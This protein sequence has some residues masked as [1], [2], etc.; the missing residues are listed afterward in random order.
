MERVEFEST[1]TGSSNRRT[2]RLFY[3][4][5]SLPQEIRTPSSWSTAKHATINIRGSFI[6]GPEEIRT[7]DL[8]ISSIRAKL[9]ST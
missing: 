4:S 6:S 7:P 2:P 3:L 1:T 5:M 8:R 9:G